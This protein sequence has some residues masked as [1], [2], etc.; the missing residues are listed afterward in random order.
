MKKINLFMTGVAVFGITFFSSCSK[1]N[2]DPIITDLAYEDLNGGD[3]EPGDELKITANFT[4]AEGLGEAR[5][6]IES[7]GT[8]AGTVQTT[9]LSGTA[10][11]YEQTIT[12]PTS[13]SYGQV[14]TVNVTVEDDNK[15]LPLSTLSSLN[16]TV[17]PINMAG[18][19]SSFMGK[20]LQDSDGTLSDENN[21]IDLEGGTVYNKTAG[22]ANSADVDLVYYYGATNAH[23][24]A[25]P[26]DQTVN[27]PNYTSSNFFGYTSGFSTQNATKFALTTWSASDFVAL[28]DDSFVSST[29]FPTTS[30]SLQGMLAQGNI[31]AF[32]TAS[33]KKG[34][35]HVAGVNT[36]SGTSDDGSGF[37]TLDIKVQQ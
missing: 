19:I 35:I 8:S 10:S 26:N 17:G 18:A 14:Y 27:D 31:I 20:V 36:P 9:E 11:A 28:S 33:G 34:L 6:S 7:N 5:L 37:I 32:E 23:A 13:A 30:N 3:I 25:A 21:M 1:D 15:D 2:N 22:E 24:F 16:F 29:N 12:V 4:D